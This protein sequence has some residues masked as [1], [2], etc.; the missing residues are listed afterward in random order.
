MKRWNYISYAFAIMA[1]C[2]TVSTAATALG[3]P[4]PG[5]GP[6]MGRGGY[7]FG[8]MPGG[9]PGPHHMR[10]GGGD[11]PHGIRRE[12][13]KHLYPV[14]LVRSHADEIK[15]S[16]SQYEKLRSTVVKVKGEVERISWDMEREARKLLALIEKGAKIKEIHAQMDRVFEHENRIKKLHLGLLLSVRDVL[17]AKQRKQLDSIKQQHQPGKGAPKPGKGKGRKTGAARKR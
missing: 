13:M 3:Q 15:L 12:M 16:D 1:A 17:T 8:H 9:G 14:E 2:L 6:G 5:G 7:P 11:G 10:M 4:A